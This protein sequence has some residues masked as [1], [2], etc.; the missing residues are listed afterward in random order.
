MN[1]EK[2]S[3]PNTSKQ[4]SPSKPASGQVRA[5]P[6]R[7]EVLKRSAAQELADPPRFPALK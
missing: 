3:Q 7:D 1:P 4:S 2:V 6:V 5:V